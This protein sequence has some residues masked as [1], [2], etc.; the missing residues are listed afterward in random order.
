MSHC[1]RAY[2]LQHGARQRKGDDLVVSMAFASEAPYERWWGIEVLVV[3]GARL[4]RLND[5]APLLFNHDWHDLR[6]VHEPGTARA[7]ADGVLR[8]DVRI[9]AATAIGRDTIALVEGDVLTKASVGYDI[10]KVVEVSTKKGGEQVAREIDGA[11]FA[12]ALDGAALTRDARGRALTGDRAAF[13]RALQ[14]L[15]GAVPAAERADDAPTIYRV[16]DWEPLENSLVTVPAD[17]T[18]GVGRAR[19][20]A[21]PSIQPAAPAAP[22]QEKATMA[23][24]TIAAAAGPA[25]DHAD[26][27]NAHNT[28]AAGG[29]MP[30]Q[31]RQGPS[32]MELERARVRG[33]EN[34]CKANKIDDAIKD[35]WIGTG[36]SLD[37]ISEDLLNILEERGKNNPQVPTKLGLTQ[38]ETR[39]F[40]LFRAIQAV[41]EKNWSNAGFELECSREIAKRLGRNNVDPNRFFVPFEVQEREVPVPRQKLRHEQ[42][43]LTVASASGGGYLVGTQNM[44]F[45]EVLRNRSVAYRMGARRLPGLEGNITIP[46]HT[47][48]ATAVWLA[49]EASTITESAQTF[50]QLALS[51]KTVGAYTEISRQLMLQ[52]SPAAEGIVTGDLG[53]VCA[54]AYDL[55]VLSGSGSGGQPTGI[56]NTAGIGSVTGTSIAYAGI[57]E[58]QTDVAGANVMPAAGG[59]VTTPAVAALLMQRVKFTSTASPLWEGN[60]WDGSMAGFQSMTSLQMAAATMLFGDWSQVIVGEWGTLEI[61]VNPYANFQAA[62]TGIR[63]IVSMDC[64]LRYAGAFSLASS[65]T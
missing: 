19:A 35:H 3:S 27:G 4:A 20:A 32:A 65:I 52:S 5:G 50:G 53:A 12:R 43:D 25:A 58:F 36:L 56:T 64:G 63:A 6:G 45:I 23:D 40:S 8:G 46:R 10:H 48:A 34:L 47:G 29:G 55:A 41:A 59:Y 15:P 22:Q 62:I 18:V 49:N 21:T 30:A 37:E 61:E 42:R 60:V 24:P 39:R 44:S 14:Q 31:P 17:N 2:N 51:P 7:D 9:T 28:R 13:Q 57:L 54:I 33:I 38:D 16:V 11:T 26:N 1:T